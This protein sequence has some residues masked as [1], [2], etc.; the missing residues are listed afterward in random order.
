MKIKHMVY[1]ALFVALISV[2]AQ[3]RI[4]VGPVPITLQTPMILLTALILG[5]KLSAAAATVYLL[6]GLTGVPVFA[7]GGGIGSFI[8]P[9]FGFIL[10]F[11]PA[12]FVAGFGA[13]PGIPFYQLLLYIYSALLIIFVFGALYFVFIMNTVIGTPVGIIE[14]LMITVIPFIIKDIIVGTLTAMFAVV[15]RRRGL[16]I[17]VN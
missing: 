15:L 9:S 6:I 8:S 16:N 4:P 3:I 1:V 7:G 5:P 13:K 14:A 17:S 2:G 10:G 11:I 12:A